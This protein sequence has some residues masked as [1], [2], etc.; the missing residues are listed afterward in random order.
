MS[1]V[2]I[3]FQPVKNYCRRDIATCDP[4]DTVLRVA[5]HMSRLR[6]SSMIVC[7][8]TAP[9]GILTDR[10]LR[11]KV[12]A[13]GADPAAMTARDI[14]NSPLITVNDSRPCIGFRSMAFIVSVLSMREII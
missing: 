13:V 6:I 1:D 14:M 7:E 2:N 12:V 8:G 9:V 11:N 5:G 10:D 4:D 3:L